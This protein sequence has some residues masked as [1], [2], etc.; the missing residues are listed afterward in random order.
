MTDL[1]PRVPVP[2]RPHLVIAAFVPSDHRLQLLEEQFD[3]SRFTLHWLQSPAE[4]L[5][6]LGD[7][8]R[9]LD[10][11]ILEETA[12]LPALLDALRDRSILL[13]AVLLRDPDSPSRSDDMPQY[14]AAELIIP[15]SALAKS[16][17]AIDLAITNFLQLQPQTAENPIDDGTTDPLATSK[18]I[19]QRPIAPLP[20]EPLLQQQHRLSE[21]LRARLGYLG[22]YY[23]REAKNFLRYLPPDEQRE[24]LSRLKEDYREIVL[25][26]FSQESTLNQQIDNLVDKAFFADISVAQVVEIHMSLME[27]FSKQLKLEGRSEEILLD[28]RLTL[29]DV[30]AHLCEMYRRSIPRET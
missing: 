12:A 14:H 28:Y 9:D 5:D 17:S 29:I 11:L 3:A 18:P 8:K 4:L 20:A 15:T 25:V 30:I 23:K 10:C 24:F 7:R 13:P 16:S 2:L 1:S 21:K 27:D 26:Y 22:V 19:P 6:F